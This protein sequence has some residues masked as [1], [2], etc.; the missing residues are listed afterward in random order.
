MS[1]LVERDVRVRLVVDEDELNALP[2]DPGGPD[3]EPRSQADVLTDELTLAMRY[4]V[5]ALGIRSSYV[6]A[7]AMVVDTTW[8]DRRTTE[9][10]GAELIAAERARQVEVEGFSVE[11]D[12]TRQVAE[13]VRAA[14]C[15]QVEQSHLVN[16]RPALLWPWE[17]DGF[18][19]QTP[20]RDL[21]RAGA[22]L[23]AAIDRL[24]AEAADH[25]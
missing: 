25:G 19:P 13:L 3:R 12:R 22:L 23:A 14:I 10:N 15:Y 18:K 20:L 17:A 16:L 21:V 24:Q 4:G 1:R 9:P 11:R 6:Q 8:G 7:V 2:A 5:D